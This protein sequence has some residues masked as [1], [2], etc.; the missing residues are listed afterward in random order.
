M[1]KFNKIIVL[2]ILILAACVGFNQNFNANACEKSE[3]PAA[4]KPAYQQEAVNFCGQLQGQ[5]AADTAELQM[6]CMRTIKNK[7]YDQSAL[8][9]CSRIR[10]LTF[11]AESKDRI[12][13]LREMGR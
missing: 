10:G 5:T 8:N 1:M 4:D 6:S 12:N 7:Q 9:F 13:C 3:K 11:A 2:A